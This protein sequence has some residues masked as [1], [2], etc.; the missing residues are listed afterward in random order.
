MADLEALDG[1]DPYDLQDEECARLDARFSELRGDAWNEPTGCEGWSRHDLLAHLVAVEEYVEACL[2]ATVQQLMQRYMEGG[3]TTLDGFN[4]AGV[5]AN[6][7]TPPDELLA[8]W[9]ERNTAN[10]AGFRAAD[11]TDIDTSVGR[12]PCR[13]QAFHVAFEYAVH[14]NDVDATVTATE[15]EHRQDWLAAVARFALTEV[16]QDVAVEERGGSFSVTKGPVQ[17]TFDRDLF[18]AGVSGRA[19]FD[20]MSPG[21]AELLDLGY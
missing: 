17:A 13:L 19:P 3:A 1:L 6:A 10:R 5:A 14:A 15:H 16:H 8:L 9:R 4:A 12:Y 11:G 18:V 21:E 7:A 2:A 20:A